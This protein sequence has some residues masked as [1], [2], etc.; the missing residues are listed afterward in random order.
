MMDKPDAMNC[1]RCAGA[2]LVASMTK[3]GVEVDH[4]RSCGGVWLDKGEIFYFTRSA[5]A[6][7]AELGRAKRSAGTLPSPVTGQPMQRL[8]LFDRIE[9]DRCADSEGLWLDQG[10]LAAIAERCAVQLQVEPVGARRTLNRQ[11]D[12][13]LTPDALRSYAGGARPLPNLFFRS[14]SLLVLLYGMVAALLIAIV[15]LG[16]LTDRLAL[17]IGVGFALVQFGLGPF[18]MDLSLSYFYKLDWV[19][20]HELPDHLREFIAKVCQQKQMKFPRMGVIDDGA[21]N[22]FTYGHVPNNARI[23]ITRGLYDLLD[24]RELEAVVAHEIGH[25]VQWDML[26]MTVAQLVPL[27]AYSLY[28]TALS[29][30]SRGK[31]NTAGARIAIAVGAYLVYIVSEYVVLWLSRTRE[32]KADNF[33]GRVTGNPNALASA[34]VKI[35]YGLAGRQDAPARAREPAPEEARAARRSLDPIGAL[36]IF[37]SKAARSLA[38]A[39]GGSTTLDP[40]H[41]KGAMRWD[42][43]NPWAKFYELHSTH[44]LIANRLDY[45]SRQAA[46]LSQPPLVVFDEEPPESY[47]DEFFVDLA[48]MVLPYLL[49]LGVAGGVAATGQPV[50]FYWLALSA[51]G[52]GMGLKTWFTYRT[53]DFPELTVAGLLRNVKV[54]GVRPVPCTVRGEVIGRGEPGLIWSEDAVIRDRTGLIFLD[55]RQPLRIWEFLFGLMRRASLEGANVVATGWYRRAPT[56]FVELRSLTAD[57]IT[58]GCYVVH[59]KWVVSLLLTVAGVFLW[60]RAGMGG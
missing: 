44:P 32:Y 39:G 22:A 19:S 35:G 20:P 15:E 57:G 7:V 25:A 16:Y 46:A 21:P 29:L 17:L 31:D 6:L 38:I 52:L 3:Q 11:A 24:E 8:V 14:V 51:F 13:K 41:L 40:D 54:S 34:L 10:E 53:G 28:R 26:L 50:K 2:K 1:P 36:G 9:I 37:D 58:R 12:G 43:W 30:R 45:L 49:A 5:K 60:M 56:P 4:C 42:L 47:W 55:Y 59:V 33:A 18:L 23:V 27:I 48:V